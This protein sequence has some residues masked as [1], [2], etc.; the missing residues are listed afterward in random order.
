SAALRL[1]P[2]PTR[3]TLTRFA[4]PTFPRPVVRHPRRRSS[5]QGIAYKTD[6]RIA[7]P[8][9]CSWRSRRVPLLGETGAPGA[10]VKHPHDPSRH[11]VGGQ[12]ADLRPQVTSP[13][14]PLAETCPVA[15]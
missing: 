11:Q 13:A 4:G 12:P 1:Q 7:F 14:R 8:L 2:S 3:T 6:V 15:R 9:G 5:G 10:G